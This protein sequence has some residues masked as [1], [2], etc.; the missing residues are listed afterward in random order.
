MTLDSKD[1]DDHVEMEV[2]GLHGKICQLYQENHL[3]A[4]QTASYDLAE[5]IFNRQSKGQVEENMIGGPVNLI[6]ESGVARSRFE[7]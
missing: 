6:F 7:E 2:K 5:R 3:P 4:M 1:S